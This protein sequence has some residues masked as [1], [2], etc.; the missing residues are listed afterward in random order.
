M[1]GYIARALHK[2]QHPTPNRPKHAPHAWNELVYGR[3]TQLVAL[4]DESPLLDKS[5]ILRVQSIT[6][7]SCCRLIPFRTLIIRYLD[8]T[9]EILWM[10][11]K[12]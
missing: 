1:P 12:N 5:G 3:S 6:G 4:P 10:S 9:L 7:T 11:S 8:E 2:F